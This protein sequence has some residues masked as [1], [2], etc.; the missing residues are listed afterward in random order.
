MSDPMKRLADN[1]RRSSMVRFLDHFAQLFPDSHMKDLVV[2]E[3][4]PDRAMSVGGRRVVNFGSD[5]FLGLDQDPRVREAVE[6]GV[7][8]LGHPQRVVAGLLQ[9]PRQRRGRGE[10]GAPGSAPRRR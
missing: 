8:A 2:D 9:R 7:R 6:R 1:L 4:G 10:A 5:S 3:L